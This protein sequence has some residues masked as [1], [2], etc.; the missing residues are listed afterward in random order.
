MKKL[1]V[2]LIAAA[3]SGV[4]LLPASRAL[5]QDWQDEDMEGDAYAIHRGHQELRYDSR[6]LR[7]DLSRGD[8]GAAAHE[9]AEMAQKRYNLERREQD[10]NNDIN[11]RYYNQQVPYGYGYS[12]RDNENDDD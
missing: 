3:L 9:Q 10:L 1:G 5:A 8:Y 2:G 12:H 11:N 7:D 6:E 4:L